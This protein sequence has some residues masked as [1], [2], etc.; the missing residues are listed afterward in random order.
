MPYRES[1]RLRQVYLYAHKIL[2]DAEEAK[3]RIKQ[4]LQEKCPHEVVYEAPTET[5]EDEYVH[6]YTKPPIRM[7]PHCEL[8]EEE[9]ENG[10]TYL[11]G[12]RSV[13]QVSNREELKKF[14]LDKDS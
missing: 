9:G 1:D 6:Y 8:T 12:N 5:K 3:S 4:L 13:I 2:R 7:C 10:F 11:D 14:A